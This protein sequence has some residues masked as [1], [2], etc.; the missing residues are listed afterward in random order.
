LYQIKQLDLKRREYIDVKKKDKA[1]EYIDYFY[2]KVN[3]KP[4]KVKIYL[5]DTDSDSDFIYGL[6]NLEKYKTYYMEERVEILKKLIKN[7]SNIKINEEV[8]KYKIDE[9]GELI[10]FIS[11]KEADLQRE[12]LK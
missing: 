7:K 2:N 12:K 6:L 4:R 11:K 5:V 3:K 10:S 9:K 1:T 8:N